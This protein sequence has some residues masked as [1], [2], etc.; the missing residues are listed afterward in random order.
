M[1]KLNRLLLIN[2]L[3]YSFEL[4][5]FGRITFLTGK[6]ASGKSTIIDAMQ[7]VMLGDASGSFFNKAANEKSGRTLESYLYGYVPS[8][9][10]Q[11]YRPLRTSAFTS[12]VALEF[13]EETTGRLFTLGF[14]A[15]CPKESKSR[16][17]YRWFILRQSGIP[18]DKFLNNSNIPLSISE[19]RQMLRDRFDCGRNNQYE[20]FDS[21][22]DFREEELLAF[23]NLSARY[24]RI[25]RKAVSFTPITN[26]TNFIS[27]YICAV[28]NEIDISAMQDSIRNY[29]SLEETAK[30]IEERISSLSLIAEHYRRFSDMK[31]KQK[32]YDYFL[33][34]V[35]LEEERSKLQERKARLTLS[36]SKVEEI[37]KAKTKLDEEI[38]NIEKRRNELLK[39]M[40]TSSEAKRKEELLKRIHLPS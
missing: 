3:N 21:G 5:D 23:G 37:N 16:F 27:E 36:T 2:W 29:T 30:I 39:E 7:L 32:L 20:I 28:Q 40:F 11:N 13:V 24:H 22:R 17:K 38:E 4:I 33:K 12:Y 25:L 15:D 9:G 1:R 10:S 31:S 19:L 35:I 6:N 34:R 26:I 14:V 18:S 8:D